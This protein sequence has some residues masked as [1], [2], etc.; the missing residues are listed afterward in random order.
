VGD[1]YSATGRLGS[2]WGG[3]FETILQGGR[4]LFDQ[5]GAI[6][7]GIFERFI[8]VRLAWQDRQSWRAWLSTR[9]SDPTDDNERVAAAAEAQRSL[10]RRLLSA[11]ARAGFDDTRT[12][13]AHY[14]SP[15]DL[16][17]FQLGLE[18]ELKLR[19]RWL[20]RLRYL[21]GVGRE[22]SAAWQGIHT[23]EVGLSIDSRRLSVQPMFSYYQTPTYLSRY[24]GLSLRVPLSDK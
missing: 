18:S 5:A 9:W 14:Y 11:V 3:G 20:A 16:Q 8:L 4:Q 15:Q 17:T 6:A 21:P 19:S 22:E 7:Q 23:V 13:S 1:P 12:V 10:H 24:F 2:N